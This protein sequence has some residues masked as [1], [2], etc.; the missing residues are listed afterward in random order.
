MVLR[1][2][3]HVSSLVIGIA[4]AGV[5]CGCA[6]GTEADNT[7]RDAAVYRSI[8]IDVLDRSGVDLDDS[9]N[10]PVLFIE[11]FD[12]D[13]IALEVQVE[14]VNGFVE[15]YEIR[16]IDDRDEAIDVELPGLP[17][18]ANSLLIGLGQIVHNETIDVR[19]EVYLSTDAVRAYRYTLAGL[20]GGWETV[21]APD[22][23]E[24]EGFVFAS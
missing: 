24:P 2:H 11:A 13:G 4:L 17:V 8:I 21:G 9:E 10:L 22:E 1:V 14:V 15:Q 12:A 16:F 7:T 5:L 6:N 18:R 23:I 20:D 19:T 3:S